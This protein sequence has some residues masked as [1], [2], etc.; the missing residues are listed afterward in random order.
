MALPL[1]PQQNILTINLSKSKLSTC[2][3]LM[4]SQFHV[5]TY[6][7]Y[8]STK[9]R[10]KQKV[11]K[12]WPRQVAVG[13]RE[14]AAA[15]AHQH[16][17]CRDTCIPCTSGDKEKKENL[18]RTV[19]SARK[20]IELEREYVSVHNPIFIGNLILSRKLRRQR[21]A[22]EILFPISILVENPR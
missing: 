4:F 20:S 16:S 14:H 6:Y 17:V 3:I 19:T 9:T 13:G 2:R 12:T 1:L 18:R 10:R 11:Q 5:R 21:E 15:L 8:C 22:F 7:I